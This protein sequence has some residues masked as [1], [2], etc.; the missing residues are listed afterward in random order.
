MKQCRLAHR[1]SGEEARK[2][3]Q[4]EKMYNNKDVAHSENHARCRVAR[5]RSETST[6]PRETSVLAKI[7]ERE[8]ERDFMYGKRIVGLFHAYACV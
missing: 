5:Q 7:V 1:R 6:G 8:K 3:E 2:R 4:G